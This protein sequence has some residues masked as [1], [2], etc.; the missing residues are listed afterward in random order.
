MLS[1]RVARLAECLK[2]EGVDAFFAQTPTSLGYLQGF[3]EDAHERFMALGINSK[4]D[5]VL[6]SPALSATQAKRVGIIDIRPW[7]DNESPLALFESLA[8]EWNLRS[9]VIAVD[10]HMPAKMLL[11]MQATLPAAL[12]KAGQSILGQLI[13]KKDDQ[14]LDLMR[15]SAAIADE[16]WVELQG[17]IRPGLT[18][19]EVDEWIRGQFRERG[20]QPTFCI[21]ASG[22]GGAEPHHLSD[23]TVLKVGDVVVTDFGGCY[24]GYQSDITR[25]VAL[26]HATQKAS[27]VYKIVYD[28]HMTSREVIRPGISGAQVDATARKV[29]EDAGFGPNFFHRLGHGIGMS[30]HEEPYVAASN[31]APLEAGNCFS[32]EPGIYLAGEFGI[33]IENIV[34]CTESGHE[35]F[36]AEP[37]ATLTVV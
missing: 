27:D 15:K 33:R 29:I 30:V 12:F 11:D 36:N 23:Q 18:E 14:E 37:P 31:S 21:V 3:P 26:G 20:A 28:A 8:Q 16:I 25:M 13:R 32:I 22:P 5:V 34:A 19:L 4:G 17:F 7:T 2:E 10:D 6:I 1:N 9:S 24:M 35:S